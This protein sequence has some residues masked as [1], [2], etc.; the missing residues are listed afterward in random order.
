MSVLVH[1]MSY[2]PNM[3]A[4]VNY[5]NISRIMVNNV[6]IGHIMVNYVSI[7]HIVVNYV[8]IVMTTSTEVVNKLNKYGTL[9]D[10]EKPFK[11]L[12]RISMPFRTRNEECLN[13]NGVEAQCIHPKVYRERERVSECTFVAQWSMKC[14]GVVVCLV[15]H[16]ASPK[17]R[18]ERFA[19]T[20]GK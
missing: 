8:S 5:V 10:K 7:D 17:S 2:W 12:M 19:S 18:V 13:N 15:N 1:T 3:S 6:S 4:L 16:A 9:N 14:S 20:F 11:D